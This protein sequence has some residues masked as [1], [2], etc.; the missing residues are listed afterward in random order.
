ME[1]YL[2]GMHDHTFTVRGNGIDVEFRG[3]K[4]YFSDT[5]VTL[6]AL[7]TFLLFY[8]HEY[9]IIA[10]DALY[11]VNGIVSIVHLLGDVTSGKS[12]QEPSLFMRSWISRC[13]FPPRE[14]KIDVTRDAERLLFKSG[15]VFF[16][17]LHAYHE[18]EGGELFVMRDGNVHDHTSGIS[19]YRLHV[20]HL[21]FDGLVTLF[22]KYINDPV[23]TLF[24]SNFIEGDTLI[25][26]C[27][28]PPDFNFIDFLVSRN[29]PCETPSCSRERRKKKVRCDEVD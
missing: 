8:V 9:Q 14:I 16:P 20:S 15:D 3:Y 5:H 17:C 13:R 21:S 25:L 29:I 19:G 28:V 1:L 6:P 22:G 23:P 18:F 2:G 4:G 27:C 7:N 11:C 12:Y 10:V 24:P 26:R